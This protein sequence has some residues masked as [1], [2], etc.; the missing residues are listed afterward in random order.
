MKTKETRFSDPIAVRLDQ[1]LLARVT[2]IQE[3]ENRR[4]LGETVRILL[5]EAVAHREARE[6]RKK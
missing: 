2:K 3:A 5:E 4:A 6:K 1:D